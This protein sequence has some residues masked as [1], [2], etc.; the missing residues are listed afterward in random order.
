MF[1]GIVG[2]FEENMTDKE[3]PVIKTKEEYE[4]DR[5]RRKARK[6]ANLQKKRL[7]EEEK[8]KVIYLCEF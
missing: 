7:R 3:I 8:N 5:K 6:E 4:R 1:S 2:V